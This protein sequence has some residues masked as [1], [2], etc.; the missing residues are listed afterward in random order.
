MTDSWV[1]TFGSGQRL[2]ST[3]RRPGGDYPANDYH[4]GDGIGLPLDNR[5]V[6]IPGDFYTARR[7]MVAIFG[8]VWSFD[9]PDEQSAG[10]ARYGL[11]EL[12][13]TEALAELDRDGVA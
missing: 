3:S 11:V 1:F 2:R 12:D 6:K 9:Y 5:Y 7:R 8:D 4:V 13:I 10:A